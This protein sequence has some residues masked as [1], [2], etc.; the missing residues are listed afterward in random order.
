MP[1]TLQPPSPDYQIPGA[2]TLARLAPGLIADPAR[3]RWN[4][5]LPLGTA[6]PIA[7][8]F[9]TSSP[10]ATFRPLTV[11]DRAIVRQ[12]LDAW[13]AV[14]GVRFIEVTDRLG[15]DIRFA[16]RDFG[17]HEGDG[18]NGES[19][20][21]TLAPDTGATPD[22]GDIALNWNGATYENGL[23]PGSFG[24]EVILHEIG[25]ALGLGHP[26]DI[27]PPFPAAYDHTL[28]TVMS[29]TPVEA[30]RTRPMPGDV[31]AAQTLYGPP[32][33]RAGA[34]TCRVVGNGLEERGTRRDD[35]IA[36]SSLADYL[37]GGAGNDFLAGQM[38]NDMLDGGTG[39]DTLYGGGGNDWL[40]A[41]PRDRVEGGAGTDTLAL[42]YARRDC[43]ILPGAVQTP[44]GRVRV[45]GVERF[46]FD[47]AGVMP[48]DDAAGVMPRD[49]VAGVMPRDAAAGVMTALS[50]SNP[51]G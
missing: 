34:V 44:G 23:E 4:A 45:N 31:A 40:F 37:L 11:G 43:R 28:V 50:L 8:S 7:F 17:V 29:Y 10:D 13:E 20:L 14:C 33:D 27:T 9:T 21:P 2:A 49:A 41:G 6:V 16:L 12:A 30:W 3:G 26:F 48:R 51:G 5:P 25:H 47:A 15:G 18:S 35:A 46:V 22:S 36:G 1:T 32:V 42:S 19:W 38:G 39:V 24:Y